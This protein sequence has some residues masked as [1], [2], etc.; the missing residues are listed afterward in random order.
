MHVHLLHQ[1]PR[2][3]IC[4]SSQPKYVYRLYRPMHNRTH[5]MCIYTGPEH[6]H[7][8]GALLSGLNV[9]LN[10]I[11]WNPVLAAKEAHNYSA[12]SQEAISRFQ[13]QTALLWK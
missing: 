9:L 3:C 12:P 4:N 5:D 6:A 1:R 7:Q 10:V 13:V 2:A 11:P 8:L